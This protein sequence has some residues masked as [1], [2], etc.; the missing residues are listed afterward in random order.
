M[1]RR[2]RTLRRRAGSRQLSVEVRVTMTDSERMMYA[3]AEPEERTGFVDGARQNCCGQVDSGEAPWIQTPSMER[4]LDQLDE[5]GAEPALRDS[6]VDKTSER[7]ALFDAFK[8]RR[9][10]YARGVQGINFR[11]DLPEAAGGGTG[12]GTFGSRQE[13]ANG[14]A[15]YATQGRRGA[16]PSSTRWWPAHLDAEHA[17]HRQ[18]F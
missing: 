6:G 11:I 2:G 16:V 14:S 3:T 8:P 13:E 18:R 5:L 4:T 12:S 17:A 9:G 10:R 7:E 1:T 15:G